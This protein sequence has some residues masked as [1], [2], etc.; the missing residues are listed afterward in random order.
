MRFLPFFLFL[1][2]WCCFGWMRVCVYEEMDY[3]YFFHFALAFCRL[4]FCCGRITNNV[5]SKQRKLGLSHSDQ[6]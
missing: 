6:P 1:F 2:F 5:N 4:I 3:E